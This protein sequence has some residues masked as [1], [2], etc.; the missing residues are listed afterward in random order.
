MGAYP[1]FLGLSCGPGCPTW[2]WHTAARVLLQA[3]C[4]VGEPGAVGG[5]VKMEGA[6]TRT[7]GHDIFLNVNSPGV[8]GE[9]LSYGWLWFCWLVMP[10]S[11]L[12]GYAIQHDRG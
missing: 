9:E 7:T 11:M 8:S 4:W 10:Y 6:R 3:G 2:G 1:C 5:R 12:V